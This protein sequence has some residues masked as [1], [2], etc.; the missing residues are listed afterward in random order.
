MTLQVRRR[1]ASEMKILFL[2]NDFPHP[3]QP[4][5]GTF[6]LNLLKEL[7][8]EQEVRVISPRS[9]VHGS[10]RRARAMLRTHPASTLYVDGIPVQYPRF[11]YP[12]KVLRT[13]YGRFMWESV[14]ATVWRLAT[15]MAWV[16]DI[17]LGYWAHPDGEVA[18]RI[19]RLLGVPSVVM[20]GGSDVL[21]LTREP[22]RRERIVRALG[23]ADA[24]VA[25]S[26]DLAGNLERLG[27]E[28]NKV[29]VIYRGVDTNRFRPDDKLAAR[30]ALGL[31]ESQPMLLWVGRMARVKA[32]DVLLESCRR[33]RDRGVDFRVCLVGDGPLRGALESS[34]AAM[35]LNDRV[36]FLGPVRQERLADWY[37]AAEYTV[38]PS[39]SEGIPN[40]L[41]ES[42]AC[43]TPFIASRVGGV[44][45]IADDPANVLVPVEDAAALADAI[46]RIL[47]GPRRELR[48]GTAQAGWD[49]CARRMLDVFRPL[50]LAS[51]DPDRPRWATWAPVPSGG[52][53]IQRSRT[54]QMI[55]SALSHLPNR[56]FVTHGPRKDNKVYLTFDDGPHP[57]HTPRLLDELGRLGVKATFFV[58]GRQVIR[59]PALVARMAAE[60]H[61]VANHTFLHSDL[62]VMSA[63]ETVFGAEE[64]RK[65]L[66]VLLGRDVRLYR[67]PRG[68]IGAGHAL[69]LWR[70]G[71]TI[72]LWSADARDWACQS[73]EPVRKW[74]R[75]YPFRG[76]DIVLMHDRLPYAAEA[77]PD[78]IARAGE[79][80][81]MFEAMELSFDYLSETSAP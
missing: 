2:S 5:R 55:R 73:A 80:G 63:A 44:P 25:L 29:H 17:V 41:R 14:R 18:V 24:V 65:L 1:N 38:L 75:E 69:G 4:T 62:R 23:D 39:R 8:R 34:C 78:L 3:D 47:S 19:A 21:V 49:Q 70:A 66:G 50:V 79:R 33:L 76:G 46:A 27:V 16:P 59:Y 60:G 12:P 64:M 56:L 40:V 35:G 74:A 32:L 45:E 28:R 10:S 53:V 51:Q 54:R 68:K 57:E 71:Y 11:Y 6:N 13:W 22:G 61:T 72:V 37:R 30:R 31:S 9:W 36:K 26:R 52:I 15:T 42:L 43:G 20:V 48:A 81:L 77:L 67:P 58:V 7:A